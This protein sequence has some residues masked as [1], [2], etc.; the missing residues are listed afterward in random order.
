MSR[1]PV[2][3]AAELLPCPECKEQL[4]EACHIGHRR[5]Q[6]RTCNRFAAAVRGEMLRTL[7]QLT[8]PEH[9]ELIRATSEA[10]VFGKMFPRE[11]RRLRREYLA[12]QRQGGDS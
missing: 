3:D 8:P 1:R 9:A 11:A 4:G 2:R 7:N 5:G 12:A 10:V 6:C